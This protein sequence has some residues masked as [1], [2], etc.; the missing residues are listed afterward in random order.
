ML[1]SELDKG[2][3]SVIHAA[4]TRGI[5]CVLVDERKARRV[6]EL[7]YGLR[8]KGSAALLLEAKQRGI[9]P[10]VRPALEAMRSG[11]YLSWP[12]PDR[13]M[14]PQGWRGIMDSGI[15]GRPVS[16]NPFPP[17]SLPLFF[18]TLF[19]CPVTM[20]MT[21]TETDAKNLV[22]AAMATL[23]VSVHEIPIPR[24]KNQPETPDFEFLFE[25]GCYLVEMKQREAIWCLTDEEKGMLASGEVIHKNEGIGFHKTLADRIDKAA[26][27]FSAYQSDRHMFRLVWYFTYGERRKL[28]TLRV[29]TTLMGDVHVLELGSERQWHAY[30]FDDNLFQ[31][32]SEVVDGA[33]VA[34]INDYSSV[35]ITLHLV[36]NPFTTR[37]QKLQSS[38]L[39]K[40]LPNSILD[41]LALEAT[42]EA[43][44]VDSA[45][46]RT[47]ERATLNY[48]GA[49]YGIN[50]PQILRKGHTDA[51]VRISNA[52][53]SLNDLMYGETR[54]S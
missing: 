46:D 49:K 19:L 20:T 11:G 13:G 2:E 43:L 26:T 8:V 34:E 21:M 53:S 10:S 45:A 28:A 14:P 36:L 24:R 4:R 39:A 33:I 22:H 48:L 5:E 40:L 31:K 38:S 15:I 9:I 23:G 47:S 37:Y 16:H 52:N 3:A 35:S 6:A 51:R 25:D 32:H 50:V 18:W 27:Q 12:E 42:G 41:P 29:I 54:H 1:L 17:L 30:F 7:V 44:I